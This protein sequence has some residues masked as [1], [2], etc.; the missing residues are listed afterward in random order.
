MEF[1][2]PDLKASKPY[3]IEVCQ[4]P[5]WVEWSFRNWAGVWMVTNLMKLRFVKVQFELSG[6]SETGV[7]MVTN[8]SFI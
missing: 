5:V 8:L 7:C 1:G 3:E 6:V 4:T 2:K